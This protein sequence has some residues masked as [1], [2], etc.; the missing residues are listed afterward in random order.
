MAARCGGHRRWQLLPRGAVV[1]PR[2]RTGLVRTTWGCSARSSTVWPAGFL[3]ERGGDRVQTAIAMGQVAEPYIPRQG[4]STPREGVR[5]SSS[6]PGS[7]CRS[8]RPTRARRKRALEV[9][10]QVVLMAK[11][12]D[13]VYDDDPRT[14]SGCPPA[15]GTPTR[16]CPS[17]NS[18]SPTRRQLVC[19]RT[20]TCR[21]WCSICSSRAISPEPPQVDRHPGTWLARCQRMA[22]ARE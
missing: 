21:S 22:V 16:G 8:S 14:Q 4:H 6:V 10:A 11:R 5:S 9:G 20:M 17:R 2:R 7:E 18:K 15:G 3:E 12:V 13:G 1:R 19:A